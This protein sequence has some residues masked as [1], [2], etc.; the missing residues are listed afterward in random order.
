[1]RGLDFDFAVISKVV[2][3][4]EV[5]FCPEFDILPHVKVLEGVRD[6]QHEEKDINTPV[7]DQGEQAIGN[8]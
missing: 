8:V 1:M 7:Y 3:L 5:E 2:I 4:V 6:L